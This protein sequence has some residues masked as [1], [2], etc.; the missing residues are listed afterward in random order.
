M[1]EAG[2][3]ELVEPIGG[4]SGALCTFKTNAGDVFTVSK[5]P[6]SK[7][8]EGVLFQQL[9]DILNEDALD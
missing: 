2:E 5:P 8:L 9:K 7:E 4:E 6:I 3:A 1:V